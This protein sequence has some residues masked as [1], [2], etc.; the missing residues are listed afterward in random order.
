M[1]EVLLGHNGRNTRAFLQSVSSGLVVEIE[2][3]ALLKILFELK[4]LSNFCLKKI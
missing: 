4:I 3:Q 1:I 2:I